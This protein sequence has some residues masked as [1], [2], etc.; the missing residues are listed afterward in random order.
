MMKCEVVKELLSDYS[1]GALRAGKARWIAEHLA[2]C[3]SCSKELARLERAMALV[4]SL[5]QH[6]PPAD[7]WEGVRDRISQP[8]VSRRHL[9]PVWARPRR[10][11]A[12]LAATAAVAA[13]TF[14]ITMNKPMV[15]PPVVADAAMSE[16]VQGHAILSSKDP[17]ADRVS[18]GSLIAITGDRSE[19]L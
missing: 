4:E 14:S 13:V 11:F 6:E 5:E 17:F 8:Q 19:E 9:W 10:V 12:G 18:L 15:P 3:E 7:L 2:E 16:Y 1:V